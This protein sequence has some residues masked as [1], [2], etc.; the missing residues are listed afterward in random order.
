MCKK[1]ENKIEELK[2]EN[3]RLRLILENDVNYHPGKDLIKENK[4]LKETVEKYSKTI[5]NNLEEI[6]KLENKNEELELEITRLTFVKSAYDDA[7]K[8]LIKENKNLK[9]EITELKK[10]NEEL[11]SHNKYLDLKITV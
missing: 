5:T 11:K 3:L 6:E 2:L 10:E 8:E 9:K 7:G 4:V 1:Y